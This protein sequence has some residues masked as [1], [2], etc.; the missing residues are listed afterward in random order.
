[1]KTKN[2]VVLFLLASIVVFFLVA[3]ITW[4][5]ISRFYGYKPCSVRPDDFP[6]ILVAP[7]NAEWLDHSTPE[8]SKCAPYTY[9]INYIIHDPY[10]SEKTRQFINNHL[11]SNG[12]Q[13]LKY[14]LMNPKSFLAKDPKLLGIGTSEPN[15]VPLEEQA[16]NWPYYKWMEDWINK[17]GEIVMVSISYGSKQLNLATPFINMSLFKKESWITHWV[18]RYKKLHPDEFEQMP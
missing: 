17:D 14:H 11:K 6:S 13:R 9:G 18:F 8:I 5:V 4:V 3:S 7:E 12:W 16:S 2:K 15:L 1:M 10:P